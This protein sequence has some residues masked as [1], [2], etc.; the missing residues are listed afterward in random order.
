MEAIDP[1]KI[2]AYLRKKSFMK[3]TSASSYLRP[4]KI[5]A[6]SKPK[7][8]IKRNP[9]ITSPD[10]VVFEAP[11]SKRVR[12]KSVASSSL[13]FPSDLPKPKRIRRKPMAS[14]PLPFPSDL[15][16]TKRV[17]SKA[18]LVSV[19]SVTHYFQKINVAIVKLKV[20]LG[21]GVKLQ[22]N[23]EAGPFNQK[24]KSMQI[25]RKDVVR[26][27]RGQEIGM[28]VSKKVSVGELVYLVK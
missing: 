7:I 8:K 15:P 23:G 20:D 5:S 16:K 24:L 22:M 11:I 18:P 10:P 14:S 4:P 28:K 13:P 9:I 3:N 27:S 26:A 17:K 6:S 1:L 12:R 25:D 19:G 21:V 2:P